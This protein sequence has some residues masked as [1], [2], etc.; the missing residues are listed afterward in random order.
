MIHRAFLLSVLAAVLAGCQTTTHNPYSWRYASGGQETVCVASPEETSEVLKLTLRQALRE[1]GF[2]ALETDGEDAR[3]TKY[4]RFTAVM[5]GWSGARLESARLE[6]RN[7][8]EARP[9]TALRFQASAPVTQGLTCRK[10]TTTSRSAC[11]L[12]GCFRNRSPGA[13]T[14]PGYCPAR[15]QRQFSKSP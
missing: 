6:L 11:S 14:K 8:G 13:Q 15:F 10:T 4:L 5:G 12:T 1:K 2:K 9:A 7:K 3:C